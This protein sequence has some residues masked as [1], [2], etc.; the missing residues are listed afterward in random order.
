MRNK[1]VLTYLIGELYARDERMPSKEN[2]WYGTFRFSLS[3]LTSHKLIVSSKMKNIYLE[4]EC[5]K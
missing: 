2:N 1:E 4:E 3:T 5:Q